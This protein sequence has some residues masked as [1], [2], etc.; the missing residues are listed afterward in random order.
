LPTALTSVL[1]TF[2]PLLSVFFAA[3]IVDERPSGLQLVGA[4]AILAGL[5]I[6]SV[7]RRRQAPSLEAVPEH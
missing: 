6:A 3:L 4:A 7:G 1:L 5:L 2:Q